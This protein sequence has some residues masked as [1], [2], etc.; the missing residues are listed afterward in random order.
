MQLIQME[1]MW[2]LQNISE[3]QFLIPIY[4][5][6]KKGNLWWIINTILQ[7]RV[8]YRMIEQSI[9]YNYCTKFYSWYT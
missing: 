7:T 6:Q 2:Y 8:Y 3:N 5:T 9:D 1:H 4:I